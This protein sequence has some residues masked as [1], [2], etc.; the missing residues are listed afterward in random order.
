[1]PEDDD[2]IAV[3]RDDDDGRIV[4]DY[5]EFLEA[6]NDKKWKRFCEQADEYVKQGL[7][8]SYTVS[9]KKRP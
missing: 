4:I 7:L 5:D 9:L 6:V 8:E 1:M 2:L 3:T